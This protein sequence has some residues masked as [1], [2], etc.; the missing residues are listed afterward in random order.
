MKEKGQPYTPMM[1]QYLD[2]KKDYQDAIVM[3]RLGDFY[4][5]FFD[6]AKI[7][8]KVLE[9]AL[10]GR[11]AGAEERVPMCGVPFHAVN[12]YVQGLID[13]GFKVAIVEQL[14]LPGEE[15]IVKRGV[16]QVI[17]PGTV[18]ED[19]MNNTDNNF[20]ACYAKYDFDAI[21]GLCDL[22]T[23]ESR[24]YKIDTKEETLLDILESNA[25]KELVKKE[26]YPLSF[27]QDRYHIFSSVYTNNTYRK[28]F[29]INLKHLNDPKMIETMSLLFNYLIETQKRDLPYLQ[30]T[31]LVELNQ[32]MKMDIFTK[33]SLE[34]MSTIR[35]NEKY[36]SLYWLL[37]H[38]K[39][40]L[41]SR[42]LKTWIDKPLI[43]QEDI[44]KRL[45]IVELLINSYIERESLKAIFN[46]VY[47]LERLAARVAYGNVNPRDLKWISNSLKIIPEVRNHLQS[48]NHPWTN[49]LLG[50]LV[51]LSSITNLIDA[52]IVDAP[53]LH[54]KDGGVIKEGFS[55]ELDEY[56][57]IRKHGKDWI[58]DFE[59]KEK[60]KTG[61]KNL[62]VGYNRVF[63]YYIEVTKS[64]LNQIKDEYN[65]T[66]KQSLANAERFFTPELKDMEN[67]ILS[68][69]D[70]ITQ[71]E[72]HLFQSVR[73]KV[74]EAVPD[75]QRV[76]KVIAKLDAYQ[77]LAN[78]SSKNGY[79]RPEFNHDKVINIK[80]AKHAVINEV[81]KHKGY[82]ENDV[83]LDSN[84]HVLMITGPNMGGK[85]TY[86][87]TVAL[88]VIMAQIG[89]FVSATKASLPIID[90]IYTRI[91]ASD[92]LISGQSTFMVEMMEANKAL[93][94]ATE[95][96]LIIFDEIGRGT[97]TF[98][99]MAI[100]QSMIEYIVNKLHTLTLFSTHYH[101]LTELSN[102]IGHIRNV[103]ASVKEENHEIVFLYKIM[104]GKANKS[105]GIN[106][107]KLANLPEAVLNRAG[108]ILNELEDHPITITES[109]VTV[110][111]EE[112][113]V[114]RYLKTIDPM[115]LSPLDALSTLIE[116]KKKVGD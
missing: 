104:E 45:D 55:T 48:L 84:Q 69:E 75:I 82:V 74:K 73:E 53:P 71:L 42:E 41:G 20:I 97:A 80:N 100:A 112:S 94:Q 7:A 5:M 62:K 93:S 68:A 30:K 87:R 110:V 90:A 44:E 81:M 76:A 43:K 35:Q 16:I 92:D 89:C 114:E 59:R 88:T 91:G 3:Y 12:R 8:S 49:E 34:L 77:A 21:V 64:F 61:I 17:T 108:E 70:K 113:E 66:R 102:T 60:E 15:K 24:V 36:G 19:A 85:S 52:A 99:G 2:I 28:A 31:Q 46:E 115:T 96:S 83:Y 38:T 98:D 56:L 107:A 1:M 22:T 95:N 37:D 111:K 67:K 13:K 101:E 79:V 105:Y 9:I 72:Y 14:T 51:D 39:C 103:N 86:M 27:L 26:D 23:G 116:L 29:E 50:D 33:N 18:M 63:G 40:A 58:L 106:V 32:Y 25:V 109:K 47:D 57:D 11:D 54:L 6:D 10:T 78:V 65:Y 4:E